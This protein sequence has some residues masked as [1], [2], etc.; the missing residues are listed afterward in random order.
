MTHSNSPIT[1]PTPTH[2][3]TAGY[4][5]ACVL[6]NEDLDLDTR[7]TL[8]DALRILTEVRPAYA[9]ITEPLVAMTLDDGLRRARL[10]LISVIAVSTDIGD[11]LRAARAAQV[12][13]TLPATP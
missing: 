9:P 3:E 7:L 4:A 12:L 1:Q 6:D 10:A 8:L 2:V 13:A 5:L 11:L